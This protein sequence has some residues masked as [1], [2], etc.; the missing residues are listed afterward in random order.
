[1]LLALAFFPSTVGQNNQESRRGHSLVRSHICSHG[2]LACLLCP[3]RF[4]RTLC[5][6]RSLTCLLTSLPLWFMG[7]KMIQWLFFSVFFAFLDHGAL[8]AKILRFHVRGVEAIYSVSG[9]VFRG[10]VFFLFFS[11]FLSFFL[12]FLSFSFFFDAI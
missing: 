8:V 7:Q 9:D 6:V 11:L 1:M 2:S 4:G 3:T 5:C 12:F 10:W